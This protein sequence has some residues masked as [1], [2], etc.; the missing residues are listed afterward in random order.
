M[1]GA[2]KLTKQQASE[3][4]KHFGLTQSSPDC[5]LKFKKKKKIILRSLLQQLPAK[6]VE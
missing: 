1:K 2:S 4:E 5:S 6:N 3:I